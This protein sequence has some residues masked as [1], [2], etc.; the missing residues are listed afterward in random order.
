MWATWIPRIGS[1]MSSTFKG[2]GSYG[3]PRMVAIRPTGPRTINQTS[4]S[5]EETHREEMSDEPGP[6]S[7]HD[8]PGGR[9]LLDRWHRE[10]KT[11]RRERNKHQ[12]RPTDCRRTFGQMNIDQNMGL[13][14]VSVMWATRRRRPQKR[15]YCRKQQEVANREAQ[16]LS[17]GKMSYPDAKKPQN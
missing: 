8:G 2:E 7:S 9:P 11:A 12:V 5:E 14:S 15:M 3:E 1:S 16:Q 10:A 6:L 4:P 17:H 13:N